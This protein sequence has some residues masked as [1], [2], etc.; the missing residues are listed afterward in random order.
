[1]CYYKKYSIHQLKDCTLLSDSGGWIDCCFDSINTAKYFIDNIINY[2]INLYSLI[3]EL[4]TIANNSN[5]GFVTI[6][7]INSFL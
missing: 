5:N 6:N 2:K 7:I 1:M 4:Q 3:A